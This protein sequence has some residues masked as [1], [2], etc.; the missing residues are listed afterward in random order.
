L[1]PAGG[2]LLRAD[3]RRTT[4]PIEVETAHLHLAPVG[5][6][7]A[8]APAAAAT[9][10]T[11]HLSLAAAGGNLVSESERTVVPAATP[12]ISGLSVAETGAPIETLQ[13][14]IAPLHPDTSGLAL[15]PAGTE[16]LTP[17]QRRQ[18]QTAAPN[19]DHITLAP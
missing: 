2:D 19:I 6:L 9:P 11:S 4:A 14:D 15:A 3:E 7:P 1:A 10:D 8:S 18:P 16:L 13:R 5:P 12:D 17:E